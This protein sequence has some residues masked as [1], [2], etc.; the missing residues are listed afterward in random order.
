MPPMPHPSAPADTAGSLAI[1]V[2][3]GSGYTPIW[4]AGLG[5]VTGPTAADSF[6]QSA[7]LLEQGRVTDGTGCAALLRRLLRRYGRL[8]LDRPIVVAC[9]PVLATPADRV[10][11][12]D[13]LTAVFGPATV[14]TL[15][16]LLD[17]RADMPDPNAPPRPPAGHRASLE[18]RRRPG[19]TR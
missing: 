7:P 8:P 5:I 11:L 3:L 2:D 4:I 10:A 15:R 19:S 14:A 6:S 12:R 13:V 17:H 9:R 16:A 18:H 1:A